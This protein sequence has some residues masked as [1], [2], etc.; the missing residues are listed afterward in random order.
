M[1]YFLRYLCAFCACRFLWAAF[2]HSP[3]KAVQRA[4]EQPC[5]HGLKGVWLFLAG[6]VA[7]PFFYGIA[8]GLVG[9]IFG[10]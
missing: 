2:R 7:A 10:R 9:I 4:V 5:E 6:L 8:A 1:K 3:P